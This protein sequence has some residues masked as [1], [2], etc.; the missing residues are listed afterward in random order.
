MMS[1]IDLLFEPK[2]CHECP[3]TCVEGQTDVKCPFD[4]MV[5]DLTKPMREIL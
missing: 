5:E 3:H 4:I 1:K 2:P